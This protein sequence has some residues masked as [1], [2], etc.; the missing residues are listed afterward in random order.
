M[1][2]QNC[3]RF[4][5]LGSTVVAA[6]MVAAVIVVAIIVAAIMDTS[7]IIMHRGDVST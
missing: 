2:M 4:E 1:V 6:I 5:S 7:R 3:A